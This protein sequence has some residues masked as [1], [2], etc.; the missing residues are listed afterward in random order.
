VQAIL[1]PPLGEMQQMMRTVMRIG[2][3]THAAVK[4]YDLAG[5]TGTTSDYRDAWF[6]GYTG[7]FVT[8]VWVGRDDNT[9]MR[10]VTGGGVPAGIWRDYMVQA[11]PRLKTVPIPGADVALPPDQPADAL[12]Q[13]INGVQDLLHGDHEAEPPPSPDEAPH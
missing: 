6:M 12:G 8:A 7:G 5:K 11:L 10:K 4:G 13:I 3:G 9:P 1:N 2:T